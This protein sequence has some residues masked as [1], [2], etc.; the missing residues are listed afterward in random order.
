L[1]TYLQ[2]T[3]LNLEALNR[4]VEDW[5]RTKD[6]LGELAEEARSGMLDRAQEADW[7]GLNAGVT[8]QFI[9]TTAETFDYAYE[10]AQGIH[11][12]LGDLVEALQSHRTR[13][14]DIKAG[15]EGQGLHVTADGRVL[16]S[17]QGE[18]VPT[19]PNISDRIAQE[20]A[21]NQRL[22]EEYQAAISRILGEV[23]ETDASTDRALRELAGEEGSSFR[24]TEYDTMSAEEFQGLV[25]AERAQEL[26]GQD[27][28]QLSAEELQELNDLLST[29]EDNE[30]FSVTLA[31]GLG[32]EG[33]LRFWTDTLT[34]P[35]TPGDTERNQLLNSLGDNLGAA[36]GTATRSNDPAMAAWE[37]QM[38]ALGPQQV[39][40][41]YGSGP[42]GYQVMSD[43]M[44]HG[45]YGEDF[46]VS[47]GDALISFDQEMQPPG[48]AWNASSSLDQIPPDLFTRDPLTGYMDAL[49]AR[50]GAATE[51]FLQR[52][53]LD[54]M[55]T[56]PID[57]AQVENGGHTFRHAVGDALFAAT[58]GMD[59]NNLG[60][61]NPDHT[62]D[63]T[64]VLANAV[65]TLAA[66]NSFPVEFR[67]PM[68]NI[69]VNHGET[70]IDS[71]SRMPSER[72]IDKMELFD[73]VTQISADDAAYGLLN[74]GMNY[75]LV[76]SLDNMPENP[77]EPLI[78]AGRTVGFLEEARR[79]VIAGAAAEEI[80]RTSL[81]TDWVNY[82]L[83]GAVDFV[84]HAHGM[85]S[86]AVDLV[87]QAWLR[88]QVAS[89]EGQVAEDEYSISEAREQQLNSL[90][91]HW[92]NENEEW[93]TL[94]EGYTTFTQSY[95]N[96]AD[97]ADHGRNAAEGDPTN[98]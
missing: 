97:A 56:R 23:A 7:A 14:Q 35:Y 75:A 9:T 57:Q 63:N 6:G 86:G 66:T 16:L 15:A 72:P 70:V 34:Q 3:S 2:F 78:N 12:V 5:S 96:M 44:S 32:A 90:T 42:Y 51:V 37:D 45:K 17:I 28:S 73:V 24:A 52:D 49:S 10:Q 82:V 53:H 43:L 46:L 67:E 91:R 47:F 13:L 19:D 69:L 61:E 79:E 55:L 65:N 40:L 58:T 81:R 4:A 31:T 80:Q 27:P 59:P 77:D 26:M 39:D 18:S 22:I 95:G 92:F 93:A 8:R 54:H 41:G 33:T 30:Y 76:D 98:K 89:V 48:L 84:P 88:D 29:Q 74:Q 1:S 38:I 20:Q 21:Q 60:L 94:S 36:L 62:Y 83:G 11:R 68:A 85:L 50:P 87:A 25:D 71:V 64:H